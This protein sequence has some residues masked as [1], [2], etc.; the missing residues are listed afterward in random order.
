VIAGLPGASTAASRDQKPIFDVSETSP[1]WSPDGRE[2]AYIGHAPDA[3]VN[4]P[5][6]M[7][8]SDGSHKRRIAATGRRGIHLVRWTSPRQIVFSVAPSGRVST[9]DPTTQHVTL[10]G[11]VL[12]L[13][14]PD[15]G[16]SASADGKLLALTTGCTTCKLY[17]KVELGIQQSAGGP[18]RMLP[19]PDGYSDQEATFSPEGTQIVFARSPLP[20]PHPGEG[21]PT[22]YIEPT[23]GGE[24]RSLEWPGWYPQWSP[25]GQWIAFYT[26]AD[27]PDHVGIVVAIVS[28]DGGK[29][30][31][32]GRADDYTR[33]P[34]SSR[35]AFTTQVENGTLGV[36]DVHGARHLIPLGHLRVG[37]GSPQWSP[38]G[39]KIAFTGLDGKGMMGVYVVGADGRGLR[40]LA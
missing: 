14:N 30:F 31:D 1:A 12:E 5:Y 4:S 32:L 36:V 13:P 39:T 2:I 22:L 38:D 26:A 21:D 19:K 40:E 25:D 15:D 37:V 20:T 27:T 23:A 16:F 10:G 17:G 6:V 11:A 7:R 9:V 18:V 28:P 33:S 3:D 34:D 8:A 29:A 24:A 35:L